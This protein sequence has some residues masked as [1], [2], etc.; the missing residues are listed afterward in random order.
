MAKFL[1]TGGCGFIGS[2]LADALISNGDEVVI[3]DDLSTGKASNAPKL[4]ELIVGDVADKDSMAKASTG[5][6]GCFHLA[7]VVSVQ[8]SLQDWLGSHKVNA[9]GSINVFECAKVSKPVIPVV[10][11]SSAAIYG[12]NPNIPLKESSDKKPLSAYGADK[13]SSELH[14]RVA[15]EVFSVPN[16]GLRFFNVYGARQDPNSPYSGVISIFVDRISKG[17][18][19]TIFG[20][21]GQ[22]RDFVFVSDVV[23]ALLSSM[24]MLKSGA[25]SCDVFNVCRQETVSIND[26]CQMIARILDKPLNVQMQP[27]RD[28]DIRLSSGDQSRLVSIL[29]VSPQF[30][31]EE[32][33][34]KMLVLSEE[35]ER[36]NAT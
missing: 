2:H 13:L 26:L 8:K 6:D 10:Y 35:N 28:G 29:G 34:R 16:I 3:L 36:P 31:L 24:K 21:G 20:D 5:V 4:A 15:S 9:G 32:G 30:S 33:L 23:S 25:I 22:V 18:G 17:K 19:I 12:N 14:G 11:A 27:A 1:I 7:A